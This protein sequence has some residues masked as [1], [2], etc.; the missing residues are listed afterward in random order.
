MAIH[1]FAH[2]FSLCRKKRKNWKKGNNINNYI[3]MPNSLDD[4]LELEY[5][6]TYQDILIL[7]KINKSVF[8]NLYIFILWIIYFDIWII[9]NK[10][11]W[12]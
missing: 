10:L 11:F 4:I 3:Y 8:R 2:D 9:H 5:F 7:I 12:Y 6:L 1:G